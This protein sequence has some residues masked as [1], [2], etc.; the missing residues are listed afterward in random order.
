MNCFVIQRQVTGVFYTIRSEN[1]IPAILAFNKKQNAK[2]MLKLINTIDSPSTT[3]QK[4]IIVPV[5]EIEF[6][7]KCKNNKLDVILLKDIKSIEKN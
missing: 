6:I 4:L 2:N 3:K 7:D 5:K 1:N